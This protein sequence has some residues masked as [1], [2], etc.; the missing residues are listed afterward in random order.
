M[1]SPTTPIPV[2]QSHPSKAFHPAGAPPSHTQPSLTPVTTSLKTPLTPA[3]YSRGFNHPVHPS[4]LLLRASLIRATMLATTGTAALVPITE[5]G[6][7]PH[8]TAKPVPMALM[9][10]IAR[11]D[12]L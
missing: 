9:S 3:E 10:G 8:S 12:A 6:P 7:P 5:P 1:K 2:P 4:P 11:P